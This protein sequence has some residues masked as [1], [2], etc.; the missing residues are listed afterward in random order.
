MSPS[1]L[2]K[3]MIQYVH[4]HLIIKKQIYLHNEYIYKMIYEVKG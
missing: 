4:I 2:T 3:A 1:V